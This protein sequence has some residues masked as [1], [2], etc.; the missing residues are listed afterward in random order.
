MREEGLE[1]GKMPLKVR[2]KF[3]KPRCSKPRC[4]ALE[5]GGEW[6][7][8]TRSVLR[9]VKAR[10]ERIWIGGLGGRGPP[11]ERHQNSACLWD[12][13]GQA[14]MEA[15]C[16][17]TGI[18]AM[19]SLRTMGAKPAPQHP[20]TLLSCLGPSTSALLL[21]PSQSESHTRGAQPAEGRV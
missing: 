19:G 3:S 2:A 14:P 18:S 8:E 10:G 9:E 4:R 6:A 20:L 13:R 1:G 17:H 16:G 5:G 11:V 21:C 15:A 7:A 12:R